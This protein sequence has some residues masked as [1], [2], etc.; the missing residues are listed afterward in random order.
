MQ[1]SA[2]ESWADTKETRKH[3]FY[4]LSTYILTSAFL[5]D[6]LAPL[7]RKVKK[8]SGDGVGSIPTKAAM[9]TLAHM[10]LIC[11]QYLALY[12]EKNLMP[13]FKNSTDD[14]GVYMNK[15]MFKSMWFV[16]TAIGASLLAALVYALP[17]Y[18]HHA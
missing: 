9:L 6:K 2:H 10:C 12:D 8:V 13:S 5:L 16:L 14:K 3:D 1:S 4:C 11:M 18:K 7:S 15:L 17:P